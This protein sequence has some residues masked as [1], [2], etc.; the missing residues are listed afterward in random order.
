MRTLL[1][2]SISIVAG[3]FWAEQGRAQEPTP[4]DAER[5]YVKTNFADDLARCRAFLIIAANGNS[6]SDDLVAFT[7]ATDEIDR[8][9]L[10]LVGAE[11]SAAKIKLWTGALSKEMDWDYTHFSRLIVKHGEFCQVLQ[12]DPSPR[13]EYWK[14]RAKQQKQK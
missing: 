5:Q 11:T 7:P 12:Q 2:F 10:M 14:A 3:V 8:F 13:F 6:A 4:T 9:L 1:L